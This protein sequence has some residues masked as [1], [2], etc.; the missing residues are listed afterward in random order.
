MKN[1]LIVL[2]AA[3]L[4][5]SLGACGG[6]P[7]GSPASREEGASPAAPAPESSAAPSQGESAPESGAAS[8]QGEDSPESGTASSQGEAPEESG[9]DPAEEEKAGKAAVVVCFSATGTTKRVAELISAETGAELLELVP[10]TAYTAEDLRYTD[11]SCRANREMAD[12]NARPAIS[13]DLSGA[14]DCEVLYL[15]YPIWWGTA[16]RIIQ[17]FLESVSLEGTRVY[18]FCTSGGSGVEQSVGDLQ[19]LY[20]DIDIVS[21]RRLNGAGQAEVRQWLESLA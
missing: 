21:G 11:D 8:S 17:T 1:L 3:G 19:R 10:E 18:L 20:P 12:E 15:G 13:G 5:L 16:P 14:A 4:V 6:T 9:A 7:S 2:L